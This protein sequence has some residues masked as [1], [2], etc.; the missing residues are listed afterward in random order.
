MF[1]ICA[2]TVL[3]LGAE[4]ISSDVIA[5]YELIK[6]A[7][8]AGSPTGAEIR[9]EIALRRNQYLAFRQRTTDGQTEINVLKSE[10]IAALDPSA[11]ES[12][13]VHCKKTIRAATDKESLVEA[14]DHAYATGGS[15]VVSDEGSGMSRQDLLDNYLVIGTASRKHAIDKALSKTPV[16]KD[17]TPF[18]GEKGIGRLSAMRLGDTLIVETARRENKYINVLEIDWSAFDDVGAMLDQIRVEPQHG[19]P[20]TDKDWNGTRLIL[21]HLTSDWTHNRVK[22]LA[23]NDFSRLT[24]PF[25]PTKSRP[26]IAIFWNGARVPVGRLDRRLLEHAHATAKGIYR[27]EEDGP[28]LECQFE[29]FDLG[30]EHPQERETRSFTLPDLEGSI[31]GTSGEITDL[32]LSQLGDFSFETYWFN[33]RLLRKIDSIGNQKTVRDLQQRWSGILLYRDGFRVLPYGEEE[34]DWLAL[35]RKA[36]ASTGY[37]LNKNQ[38]VGCVSISRLGNPNLIDQTNREGLR[39]CPE[40]EA[41]IELL[42]FAVQNQFGDF[43][44]DVEKRYRDQPDDLGDTKTDVMSLERRA[45]EALKRIKRI[46]PE[47]SDTLE[48][49]QQMFLEVKE[50][51]DRAQQRITQ[52]ENENQQMVHMAGVGLMVEVVAH[53][54]ARSTENALKAL[55]A[56]RREAVPKQVEGL[57]ESLR[58]EMKSVNKRIRILDPLSV[59]GRQRRETFDLVS[60][61]ADVLGGHSAQFKRHHI[62]SEF[63]PVE[64]TIRIKAVKGMLVQIIENL[65]SNSIYWLDLRSKKE[66]D[67]QPTIVIRLEKNPLTLTYEDNGRG[68]APD[69][70]EKVFRAFYSLKEKSKRRGLGLFIA[71]ECA[72]YHEGSLILDEHINQETG[73]LHRFILQLPDKLVVS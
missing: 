62:N 6:N 68:V 47:A 13:L 25:S 70:R 55:E 9:F 41:F 37:L 17:Q 58:A 72:E 31:T 16:S 42:R 10:I 27:C 65:L 40:Q 53:E 14:L 4:L 28:V 59:S 32:A 21:G 8:D 26:R 22:Q 64:K 36:F 60:L 49:V 67:F 71:R 39:V 33:R 66:L 57:L 56:L 46:A 35:D 48:D 45:K 2:R 73:R 19:G 44:R 38:F 7:F 50:F 3:E 43:L 15:I 29:A 24:D 1:K 12:A 5:F 61:V 69:N 11:P 54:L 20:K 30:F 18:L 34:D 51:F 52:V 63:V 23:D